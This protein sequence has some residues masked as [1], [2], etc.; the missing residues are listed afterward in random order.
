[1]LF[2]N[3]PNERDRGEET[4]NEALGFHADFQGRNVESEGTF[5]LG[6]ARIKGHDLLLSASIEEG[7]KAIRQNQK[8]HPAATNAQLKATPCCCHGQLKA[9]TCCMLAPNRKRPI[10]AD[11]KGTPPPNRRSSFFLL[12]TLFLLLYFY[13]LQYGCNS[14][15][16]IFCT[17]LLLSYKC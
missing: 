1:M 8:A 17:F 15:G 10:E 13:A 6:P 14:V 3:F 12:S 2:I 16:F 5:A 4:W 11:S 9:M 7:R